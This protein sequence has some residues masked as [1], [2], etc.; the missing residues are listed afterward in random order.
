MHSQTYDFLL[1]F[2]FLVISLTLKSI[3]LASMA[4]FGIINRISYFYSFQD[5]HRDNTLLK[6]FLPVSS[7]ILL[8]IFVFA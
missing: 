1:F 3:D 2:L 6:Q 8:Y 4:T 5:Q 7:C